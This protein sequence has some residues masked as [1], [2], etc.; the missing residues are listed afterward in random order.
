MVQQLEYNDANAQLHSYDALQNKIIYHYDKNM[1]NIGT[2]DAEGNTTSSTYDTRGNLKSKTDA[3]GNM[4]TMTDATG[5]TTR[6]YDALN[7]NISKAVPEIGLSTYEYDLPSTEEGVYQEKT[8][9][10]KGNVTLKENDKVGRLSKVTV[11]DKTTVYKYSMNGR[12][13]SVT[14]PDGTKETYTYDKVN[15]V[16][17]LKNTKKDSSL[18]SSYEYTYDS[19]GNVLTKKEEKGITSYIY[20]E[21]NRLSSVTEPGG[22]TTSYDYDGAGNRVKETVTLTQNDTIA[23]A[24]TNYTYNSQNRLM[25]TVSNS[26]SETRYLYDSNG[27]M[28]SKSTLSSKTK[29]GDSETTTELPSYNIVVNKG[30]GTGTE[31]ITL[32]FY[33]KFNRQVRVKTAE[34]STTYRYNAQGYRSEKNTEGKIIRYLYE[35]DKVVLETDG[36]N[37][38]TAYQAYGTN[39]LYR[40]VAEETGAEAESY[41]YLY[42]SH[43]DVTGLIDAEGKLA[44]TYDYDAFG[45]II[46]ETGTANNTVKY[47]GYQYDKETDLYY[48][49]A[50]YYDS[51]IARFLTEDTYRGEKT[52][53]LSLNLYTYAHN[54]PILYVDPSGHVIELSSEATEAEKKQYE[55]AIAY[56]KTS[57]EGKKL[58]EKLENSEE[59]F[60]IVFTSLPN[61][62]YGYKTNE[63]FWNM[64]LGSVLDDGKSVR[65]PVLALTHE[66]GHAAQCLSGVFDPYL[67]MDEIPDDQLMEIEESNLKKYENPI[68][69]ELGEFTRKN[70]EDTSG[71]Y[72]VDSS[73]DWGTREKLRPWWHYI[74]PWNW[75]KPQWDFI[76]LNS[77]TP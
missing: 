60:T 56:L 15:N 18:I 33:D 48:V 32:F 20:D 64:S 10:P 40:S 22:K 7:R 12:R 47:A 8:T 55:R 5:T 68:A 71:F 65:S 35:G 51:T 30:S 46:S 49:N 62:Y 29:A 1:R 63:I 73:T 17:T 31:D 36:S 23:Q 27:N 76:N 4:L 37:N 42:N 69:K 19:N 9:D 24:Y 39:L 66:M 57:K 72:K 59:V 70:Y 26:G 16:L 25:K 67:D 14:Y 61:H 6:T 11:D 41:Y 45:T 21:L 75:G 58:I 34:A 43:G 77:W 2:T 53:P 44:V 38:Q 3:N 52:D 54:N 13:T 50:R 28:V 74:A